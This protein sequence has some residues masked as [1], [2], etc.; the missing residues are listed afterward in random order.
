MITNTTVNKT[1]KK[2]VKPDNFEY[3]DSHQVI[4]DFIKDFDKLTFFQQ[5][6]IAEPIHDFFKQQW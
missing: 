3:R 6:K 5:R 1:N 2:S 4:D